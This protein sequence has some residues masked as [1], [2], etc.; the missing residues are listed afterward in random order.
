MLPQCKETFIVLVLHVNI[1]P[2]LFIQ[3]CTPSLMMKFDTTSAQQIIKQLRILALGGE[4]LPHPNTLLS[5]LS[6]GCKRPRIFNLY[7]ITEVSSWATCYEVTEADL[8]YIR[9]LM[10]LTWYESCLLSGNLTSKHPLAVLWTER[11]FVSSP[12]ITAFNFKLV[13]AIF[14]VQCLDQT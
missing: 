14:L 12:M 9:I 1:H 2:L 6:E 7:G 8:R 4:P 11:H 3:Q 5:W 10:K 13:C